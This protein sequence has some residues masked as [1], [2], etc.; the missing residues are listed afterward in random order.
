MGKIVH[1]TI[2][3][4]EHQVTV[5]AV[6]RKPENLSQSSFYVDE[7]NEHYT[8]NSERSSTFSSTFNSDGNFFIQKSNF[9]KKRIVFYIDEY[10]REKPQRPKA[11]KRSKKR[12]QSATIPTTTTDTV[13]MNILF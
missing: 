8:M 3:E 12:L 4:T 7:R 1:A 9:S 11:K 6:F 13:R 10:I 2:H 5:Q